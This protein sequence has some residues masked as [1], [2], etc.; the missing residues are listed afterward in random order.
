MVFGVEQVV[1]WVFDVGRW[2]AGAGWDGRL[3]EMGA[4]WRSGCG[5]CGGNVGGGG[6]WLGDICYRGRMC[7]QAFY[8]AADMREKPCR[9]K[10][11]RC[12]WRPVGREMPG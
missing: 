2:E 10:R 6:G 5:A 12:V 7:E 3:P 1:Q 4:G 8:F 11:T 9:G